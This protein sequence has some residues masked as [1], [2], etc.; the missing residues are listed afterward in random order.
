[1]GCWATTISWVSQHK[2]HSVAMTETLPWW[3]G[4]SLVAKRMG[5]TLMII[6]FHVCFMLIIYMQVYVGF[7]IKEIIKSIDLFI[8]SNQKIWPDTCTCCYDSVLV[9][10]KDVFLRELFQP[11]MTLNI[12]CIYISSATMIQV[13]YIISS[14]NICS[15]FISL[16]MI[17]PLTV[18]FYY[19]YLWS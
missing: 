11:Q 10:L 1:M 3:Q 6:C 7:L 15:M 17:W 13:F 19:F 18:N 2:N 16:V 14:G 5:Y 4:I 8:L 9:H 12:D